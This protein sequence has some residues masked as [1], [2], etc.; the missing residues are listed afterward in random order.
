M[1]QSVNPHNEA[2]VCDFRLNYKSRTMNGSGSENEAPLGALRKPRQGLRGLRHRI[3]FG[4]NTFQPKS[5]HNQ[6]GKR[7]P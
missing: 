6:R 7:I 1:K 3:R 2:I 4:G 5:I